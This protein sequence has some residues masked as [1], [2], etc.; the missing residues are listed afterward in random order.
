MC[1][2]AVLKEEFFWPNSRQHKL[3]NRKIVHVEYRRLVGLCLLFVSQTVF[4]PCHVNKLKPRLIYWRVFI[5]QT[6][7]LVLPL[8]NNLVVQNFTLN[9]LTLICD[10]RNPTI[11]NHNQLLILL[12]N[13][14]IVDQL[15]LPR[16][17]L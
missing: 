3:I 4:V 1:F 17:Q 8:Q 15:F 7:L 10:C 9:P 11:L 16:E 12:T 6:A 13:L 14:F 2:E 5:W